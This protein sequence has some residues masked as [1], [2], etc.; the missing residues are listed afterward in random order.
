MG[1][2]ARFIIIVLTV[3][4]LCFFSPILLAIIGNFTIRLDA[5]K[6]VILFGLILGIL[7]GAIDYEES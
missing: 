1:N 2:I 3:M 4:A 5:L 6:D 7:V